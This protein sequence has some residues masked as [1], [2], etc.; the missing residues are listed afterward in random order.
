MDR[1][2]RFLVKLLGPYLREVN[3]WGESVT[4]GLDKIFVHAIPVAF[5]L[6]GNMAQ[7]RWDWHFIGEADRKRKPLFPN[8]PDPKTPDEAD[9]AA[10]EETKPGVADNPQPKKPKKT[11]KPKETRLP[12]VIQPALRSHTNDKGVPIDVPYTHIAA[13]W[14]PFLEPKP[15]AAP[16]G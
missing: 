13:Q 3:E 1:I 14:F 10:T 5:L 15:E 6:F 4:A 16:V 7:Y 2:K 9:P 12:F 11:P 8:E